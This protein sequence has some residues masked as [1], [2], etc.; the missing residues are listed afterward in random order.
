MMA[1]LPLSASVID[2]SAHGFTV[3]HEVVL[4]ATPEEAYKAFSENVGSW[5]NGDHTFS[6]NAE[7]MVFMESCLCEIWGED[8]GNKVE[9]MRIV[10]VQ[11]PMM[12]R[13]QGGLGPLQGMAVAGSMTISFQESE[14]GTQVTM[15]YTVG[16]YYPQGLAFLA[17]PVDGVLGEQMQRFQQ[18]VESRSN[19]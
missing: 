16:G 19:E 3:K 18:F 2:S 14:S 11:P 8:M 1:L 12:I 10:N 6:G 15:V 9:H 17:V 7:S 13:M 4:S 5:W